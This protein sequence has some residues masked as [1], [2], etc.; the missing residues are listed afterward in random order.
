VRASIFIYQGRFAAAQEP[1]REAL[2]VFPKYYQPTHPLVLRAVAWEAFVLAVNSSFK[3]CL[4]NKDSILAAETA[5]HYTTVAAETLYLLA[6][7]QDAAGT[8]QDAIHTI[9]KAQALVTAHASKSLLALR[10]LCRVC[11][12]Q[13]VLAQFSACADTLAAAI[14]ETTTV[15]HADRALFLCERARFL[16]KSSRFDE[17]AAV[18][19]QIESMDPSL[20]H[21]PG[22]AAAML[23]AR[24]LAVPPSTLPPLANAAGATLAAQQTPAGKKSTSQG[25]DLLSLLDGLDFSAPAAGSAQPGAVLPPPLLPL[26]ASDASRPN[27]LPQLALPAPPSAAAS[28]D[29]LALA[30]PGSVASPPPSTL[31]ALSCHPLVYWYYLLC[32]FS[33]AF[34]LCDFPSCLHIA[35]AHLQALAPLGDRHPEVAYV[36]HERAKVQH[37]LALYPEARRG[38]E[39]ASSIMDATLPPDHP[40][41]ASVSQSIGLALSAGA[42]FAEA[43]ERYCRAMQL[44]GMAFGT[45]HP[46]VADTLGSLAAIE[47]MQGH[48]EEALALMDQALSIRRSAYGSENHLDVAAAMIQ[49]GELLCIMCKFDEARETFAD[50]LAIQRRLLGSRRHL[51]IARALLG[52]VSVQF[53]LGEYAPA[54]PLVDEATDIR[55][56]ILGQLHPDYANCLQHRARVLFVNGEYAQALALHEQALTILESALGLDHPDVASAAQHVGVSC[57]FVMS[58]PP[59]ERFEKADANL[60]RALAI[61]RVRF[62]EQHPSVAETLGCLGSLRRG[63]GNLSEARTFL[64]QSLATRRKVQ[65]MHMD[66]AR[67]LLSLGNLLCQQTKHAEAKLCFEEALD[68]SKQIMGTAD[69][70]DVARIMTGLA[71]T[72]E[73]AGRL[74]DAEMCL[75]SA[76]RMQQTCLGAQHRETASSFHNLSLVLRAQVCLAFM[77]V[78]VCVCVCV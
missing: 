17:A 7:T 69:H 48:V 60:A 19:A 42:G 34:T 46:V 70:P 75:Q 22:A 14:V 3:T 29:A 53:A 44:R 68:I 2:R 4:A 16:T 55:L 24:S 6:L 36:L 64:E 54:L 35:E 38:H 31:F 66:V 18:F 72:H 11:R 13:V 71:A 37:A 51:D 5:T 28:D 27:G 45:I 1:V 77:C 52:T 67:A 26:S 73:A 30:I 23:P 50:A 59:K 9:T 74:R 63:Q 76:L 20:A 41:A 12:I 32:R 25:V 49:Q 61:R 10:S 78:C 62:G 47:R 40:W 15:P 33:S 65:P 21:L 8:Y 43:Q 56:A 57:Q 58:I 39:Q